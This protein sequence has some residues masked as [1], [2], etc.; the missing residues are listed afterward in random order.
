MD[1][2]EHS[3][4][5]DLE[6]LEFAPAVFDSTL[7]RF[8]QQAVDLKRGFRVNQALKSLRTLGQLTR[9]LHSGSDSSYAAISYRSGPP[10]E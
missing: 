2:S 8:D 7:K 4:H 1:L 10:P 3:H 5:H 6:S 9:E